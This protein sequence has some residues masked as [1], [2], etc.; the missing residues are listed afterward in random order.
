M[1][2]LLPFESQSLGGFRVVFVLAT[3][4]A[5][6]PAVAAATTTTTFTRGS[7]CNLR[8][9]GFWLSALPLLTKCLR[10][11]A[12][13]LS[14]CRP[15][16]PR[17]RSQAG[18]RRSKSQS[19]GRRTRSGCPPGRRSRDGDG[20]R[21]P[22]KSFFLFYH[23]LKAFVAVCLAHG[24]GGEEVREVPEVIGQAIVASEFQCTA[25]YVPLF[26]IFIIQR[27][28]FPLLGTGS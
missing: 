13:T 12:G 8:E 5:A 2:S 6:A 22:K 21:C 28:V 16:T 3:A 11:P 17:S 4:P 27:M 7:L 25:Y 10:T 9:L 1:Y 19:R 14:A 26:S 15:G 23:S 18:R 20:V 24:V